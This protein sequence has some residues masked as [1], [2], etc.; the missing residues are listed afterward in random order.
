VNTNGEVVGINSAIA[1]QGSNGNIGVGF[2]ISA[3]KAKTVTDQLAKGA[4]VSHP[5]I[6]VSIGDS[7]T[8]GAKIQSVVANGPAAK[9]GLQQ[10]DV[11]T[12]VGDRP[13]TGTEDLIGAIQG[14]SVG[15]NLQLTVQR[16]GNT[17]TITVTVG[18]Q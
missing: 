15:A 18:E 13:I 5:Y 1:T 11:V 6:G 17:Q 7:D 2:A 4:K 14:S 10:G 12:K 16:G 8:G 3:N 9:A